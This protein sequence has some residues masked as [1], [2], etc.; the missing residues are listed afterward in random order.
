MQVNILS[1]SKSTRPS[2]DRRVRSFS[3]AVL[4]VLVTVVTVLMPMALNFL[5]TPLF[6]SQYVYV[7]R[8]FSELVLLEGNRIS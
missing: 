7:Y 1:V 6:P 5:T 2:G 3:P 4:W 8:W